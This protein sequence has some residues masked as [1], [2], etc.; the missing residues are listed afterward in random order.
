MKTWPVPNSYSKTIPA[1]SSPGA[2]WENRGDR[3]HC[4]VDIYA[5][6]GSDVVSIE[7]GTVEKI[8]TSS[9]PDKVSYCNVTKFVAIKNSN[10]YICVYSELNDIVIRVGEYVKPGQLIGH[11][12]QILNPQKVDDNSPLY[13]QKAKKNG[14]LSMLHFELYQA[15]LGETTNFPAGNWFKNERP[16]NLLDPTDYLL[17]ILRAIAP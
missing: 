5:P 15:P 3:F 1:G 2:F 12:G 9:S 10:G 7:D 4:G 17:S 8:G 14:N 13:I 11:V 6:K 16:R